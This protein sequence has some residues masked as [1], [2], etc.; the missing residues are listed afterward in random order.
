MVEPDKTKGC[1]CGE[2]KGPSSA[3]ENFCCGVGK[4]Q[5]QVVEE[6]PCCGGARPTPSH[7][8]ERAGYR[9]CPY[10]EGLNNTPV[11]P[12]PRIKRSWDVSDWCGTAAVP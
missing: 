11:G 2:P 10:V 3:G 8:L 7:L 5:D 1:G 9:L 4:P 12:V 6:S